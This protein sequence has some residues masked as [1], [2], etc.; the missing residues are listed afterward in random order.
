MLK[1]LFLQ[2]IT[3][4]RIVSFASRDNELTSRRLAEAAATAA[5]LLLL[6]LLLLLLQDYMHTHAEL[7]TNCEIA[8]AAQQSKMLTVLHK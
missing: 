6:L 3:D 2:T 7:P 8:T 5:A 4:Q 1:A